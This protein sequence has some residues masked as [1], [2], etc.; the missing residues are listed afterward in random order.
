[1][2][3]R[4]PGKYPDAVRRQA[5][6]LVRKGAP[7]AG[8][9]PNRIGM[10]GFS[11]GGHVTLA[12]VMGPADGR[13]DFAVPVYAAAGSKWG[14]PIAVPEDAPPLDH[15]ICRGLTRLVY[16]L[17]PLFRCLHFWPDKI[18]PNRRTARGGDH[19]SGHQP[20]I[21]FTGLL[22]STDQV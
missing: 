1:M 20:K 10:I 2:T 15:F 8:I 6:R 5:V 21:D 17:R 12:T 16:R 7:A 4:R 19:A 3:Q 22:H 9:N 11:A 18:G 14:L 13:P